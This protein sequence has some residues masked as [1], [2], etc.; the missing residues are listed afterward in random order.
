MDFGEREILGGYG[1]RE[2]GVMGFEEL[3]EREFGRKTGVL[4]EEFDG[5]SA[6]RALMVWK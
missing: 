5:R 4:E 6:G 3:L 2:A 1:G